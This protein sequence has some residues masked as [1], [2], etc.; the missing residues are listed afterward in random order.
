MEPTLAK[1]VGR[2]SLR[3][4]TLDGSTG[5]GVL[6]QDNAAETAFRL[7]SYATYFVCKIIYC[8]TLR[9]LSCFSIILL[10]LAFTFSLLRYVTFRLC[11][12]FL[13]LWTKDCSDD[14]IPTVKYETL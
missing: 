14:G 7:A 6:V 5:N 2:L 3:E 8:V 9:V 4:P 10:F 11:T 1:K 12:Y 13:A